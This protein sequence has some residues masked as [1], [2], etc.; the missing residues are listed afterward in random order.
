MQIEFSVRHSA[1]DE[2]AR[3][4]IEER[5]GR[6]TRFLREPVEVRVAVDGT[7]GDKHLVSAEAHV[8]HRHGDL[9]A[10]AEHV[11]LREALA[12]VASAIEKQARRSRKRAVDRRRRASREAAA[13]RQWPVEILER[14]SLRA[15]GVP[16]IVRS[17]SFSIE[18]MT[19]DQAALRLEASR[20][21]F[22]VFLD[23]DRDR[24]SV[25]YK[26]RDDDYGLIAP[27]V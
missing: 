10:R 25:L 4:W 2:A 15:G 20:N 18:P 17:S 12:E 14:E 26:R 27:D 19:L 9:H 22:V 21:E 1:L 11:D 16:R 13:S 24:V 23:S 5:I 7:A 6:A 8:A 3:S